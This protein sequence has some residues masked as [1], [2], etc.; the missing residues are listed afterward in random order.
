[1]RT[2]INWLWEHLDK[3]AHFLVNYAVVVTFVLFNQGLIGIGVAAALSI[4]KEM[5]D[6]KL[7]AGD[8][9]AD[10]LGILAAALL[11]VCL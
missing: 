11:W 2:I 1:M 7:S 10:I 4:G 5:I 9:L 3:V 8:V 6:S